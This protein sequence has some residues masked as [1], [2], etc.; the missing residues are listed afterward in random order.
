[1]PIDDDR[2]WP[3]IKPSLTPFIRMTAFALF[4]AKVAKAGLKGAA[5]IIGMGT[6][7]CV[8]VQPFAI[9]RP[10]E[11][12]AVNAPPQKSLVLSSPPLNDGCM[13]TMPLA[14]KSVVEPEPLRLCLIGSG[15]PGNWIDFGTRAPTPI[16]SVVK[17]KRFGTLDGS[18]STS[19]PL[20][21]ANSPIDAPTLAPVLYVQLLV[22]YVM[23]VHLD[24]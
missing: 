21:P 24:T 8:A 5:S 14:Q 6:P 1:M 23:F 17:L 13:N 12:S 3:S 16:P 15:M 9:S 19:M 18:F 20:A 4:A 11:K 22:R 7:T 2:L 10:N